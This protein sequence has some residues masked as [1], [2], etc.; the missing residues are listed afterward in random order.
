MRASPPPHHGHRP[1]P[2]Q[3]RWAQA[4]AGLLLLS[5]GPWLLLH[6]TVGAGAD[7]LPHPAEPWLM[8]LH[9][10]AAFAALFGAGLLAGHHVPR[11]WHLAHRP[12]HAHQRR[13]GLLLL[14]LGVAVVLS[15][16]TLYYLA[17][18]AWRPA[19]GWAHAGL[20]LAGVAVGTW[21]G[22]RRRA[23]PPLPTA[24]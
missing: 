19:L 16:Y 7:A 20:G 5:G 4:V 18:E 24:G 21:H 6:Y 14:G 22:R 13:S 1:S 23:V 9:G 8:R 15:G 10:A 3:R 17:P 12:R 11:S 2:F